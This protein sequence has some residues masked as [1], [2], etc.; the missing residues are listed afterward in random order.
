LARSMCLMMKDDRSG[1]F[2]FIA[3]LS[4]DVP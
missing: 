2:Q 4:A 3:R 1:G